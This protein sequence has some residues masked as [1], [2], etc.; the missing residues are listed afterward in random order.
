MTCASSRARF[1]MCDARAAVD[2]GR[3]LAGDETDLERGTVCAGYRRFRSSL[4]LRRPAGRSS[5]SNV[6]RLLVGVWFANLPLMAAIYLPETERPRRMNAEGAT[7]GYDVNVVRPDRR[8]GHFVGS[9]PDD[10]FVPVSAQRIVQPG[11]VV[12]AEVIVLIEHRKL[13]APGSAS[14]LLGVDPRVS[15]SSACAGS[16]GIRYGRGACDDRRAQK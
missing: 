1:L 16:S 8:V 9:R 15:P 3:V 4:S 6:D 11:G 2:V 10:I 7:K 5:V 14:A 13:R 12:L